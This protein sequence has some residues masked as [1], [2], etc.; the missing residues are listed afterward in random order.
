LHRKITPIFYLNVSVIKKFQNVYKINFLV[1]SMKK[2]ENFIVFL[3]LIILAVFIISILYIQNPSF[4][5]FA[6]FS[7]SSQ[8]DFNNGTYQDT[9]YNG[10]GVVLS[11]NNLSGNYTSKIFDAGNPAAWNNLSYSSSTPNVK[12]L[13]SVDNSAGIW[14]STDSGATWTQTS[15]DYNPGY[16]NLGAVDIVKNS[17]GSLFVANGQ[18]LWKSDDKGVTW[19]LIND[20]INGAGDS[21][22]ASVIGTD[23]DIIYIIDAS[24]DVLKS[25]NSGATFIKVNNSDFNNGNGDAIGITIDSGVL[26]VVDAQ[27]DVWKSTNSGITWTLVKDDYNGGKENGANDMA[28]SSGILWILDGQDL[29]KSAD[30]G[31]SWILINDDFNYAGDSNN[32]QALTIDS[33]SYI[34][35]ADSSEDIY[36]STDSGV[37]FTRTIQNLNAGDG[38]IKGLTSAVFSTSLNFQV[39]NCSQPDCS[40]SVWQDADLENINLN[41]RYFQYKVN[42]KSPDSSISPE[43]SSIT[44]DY[45]LINTPPVLAL[46]LPADGDSYGTNQSIPLKFSVSDADNNLD[47]CW[48]N[49]GAGNIIILCQN[50]SFNVS[51]NGNYNITIYAN[52]SQNEISQDSAV[53]SVSL[54]S[55]TITLFSPINAYLNSQQNIEFIYTATDTD[56]DYCELWGDFTGSFMLNQTDTEVLSGIQDSFKLNLSDNTYHWN[57]RCVDEQLN[58][59]FNG[60]KTFYVDTTLPSII[61]SQPSGSK[62]SRTISASWLVSDSSPIS[63]KYNIYRGASPEIANKSVSCSSSASFEV[64]SD[65]SFSFNLY[66]NDSAGNKNSAS[67]L[68]SVDTSI[69]SGGSPGGGGGG[70][71]GGIIIPRKSLEVE[72]FEDLI[73]YTNEVRNLQLKIKNTG[74]KFLNNCRIKS[75]EFI[76]SSDIKDINIG[77][78]VEFNMQINAPS[79]PDETLEI[80]MECAEKS[81]KLSINI[82]VIQPELTIEILK[83]FQ[84]SRN[85]LLLTYRVSGNIDESEIIF[86]VFDSEENLVLEQSEKV[87]TDESEKQIVLDVSNAKSGM[88][89]ISLSSQNT[90]VIEEFFIYDKSVTGF[91]TNILGSNYTYIGIILIM[92]LVLSFCIIRRI[93]KNK[94]KK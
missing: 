44:L 91:I 26:F 40:D 85:N 38:L 80:N 15:S 90:A 87:K 76:Q 36:K 27:S 83:I 17:S 79:T 35:I 21:N 62:T 63:C 23:G 67:S 12:F 10:T 50:T 94:K 86:K 55:P 41:A 68:F 74:I 73:I 16:G 58:S 84:E 57:I 24:E 34:Y 20:D 28:S 65:A 82:L 48:Y 56:L 43:L 2:R 92:F 1:K 39:R 30:S 33:T 66:V 8:S 81:E 52:D 46:I 72:D 61:I 7:Q 78:I 14:K 11:G 88:L 6:V 29:W 37:N 53:F 51:G 18:D 9:T 31:V 89:K 71:G 69:P 5:G 25:T 3:S 75:T 47:S 59:A 32:G 45:D 42:F 49:A 77:E 54:G 13:F 19:T 60:N 4:T 70:G 22:E 93:L 64:S